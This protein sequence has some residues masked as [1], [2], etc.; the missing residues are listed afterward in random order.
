MQ[1]VQQ[2]SSSDKSLLSVVLA[3]IFNDLRRAPIKI[4]RLF[5]REITFSDV[6]PVFLGLYSIFIL[7]IVTTNITFVKYLL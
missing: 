7:F 5:K 3:R 6:P 1:P 2:I 4:K